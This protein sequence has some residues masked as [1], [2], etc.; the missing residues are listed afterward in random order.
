M[1]D[2]TDDTPEE[3]VPVG[4]GARRT[5]RELARMVDRATRDLPFG[6][7]PADYLVVRDRLA[8]PGPDTDR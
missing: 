8:E 6:S 3:T 1:T 2:S 5:A 4:P 7:E